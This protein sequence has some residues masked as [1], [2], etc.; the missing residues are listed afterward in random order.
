MSRFDGQRL[1]PETF[2]LDLDGLRSGAYSDRYF[3][4]MRQVFSRLAER[5]VATGDCE[6]EMQWFCRR[7]PCALV[8]GVDEALAMLRL[9]AGT[10]GSTGQPISSYDQLEVLAVHDG[11]IVSYHGDPS[12]VEPVL[13]VRGRYRDFVTLETATLGAL[14]RGSRVATN[15]YRVL[16]AA[17][18]KP[19]LFFPARFDLHQTQAADGYAYWIAVQRYNHDNGTR[20]R[21]FISTDAQGAWWG[22]A[23]SGTVAHGYIGAFMGDSAAAMLAFAEECPLD[24]PRIALVD[25]HN[26]C[27]GD[28]IRVGRVLFDRW[29]T[30]AEAGDAAGMARYGLYAVRLDT[31]GDMLDVSLA[32]TDD[33]SARGVSPALVR[34]VRRGLDNAWA[35]WGVTGARR[36]AARDYC[37]AVRI[38]ATGG[39]GAERIRAFE[40]DG[41]PVDVYGVGSALFDNSAATGTNTDFTADVVR[42][43]EGGEWIDMAKTGRRACGNPLLERVN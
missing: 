22:G 12:R 38:V 17:G 23:G 31:S 24:V 3:V 35:E 11:D 41:V 19:V 27:V 13:V 16:E 9:C 7:R 2:G 10:A 21:P 37:R 8:A 40:A 18:G 28:S 36:D 30:C 5:G 34:A 1:P 25:Y 33:P 43:R 14:S 26:D 42:I 6:V 39:F 20:V 15:V 4:N 32:G 29:A